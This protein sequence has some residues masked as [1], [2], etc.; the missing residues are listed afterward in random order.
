[1]AKANSRTENE[2]K[3][4][5]IIRRVYAVTVA[6]KSSKKSKL[7]LLAIMAR[8]MLLLSRLSSPQLHTVAVHIVR[9]DCPTVVQSDSGS[10][11]PF[12]GDQDSAIHVDVVQLRK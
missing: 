10:D 5:L 9:E 12:L 4:R 3:Q 1:M 8:R 6:E 7:R 2:T 11:V